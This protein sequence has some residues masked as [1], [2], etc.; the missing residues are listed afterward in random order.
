[1]IYL[2]G[3]KVWVATESGLSIIDTLSNT[4]FNINDNLA[5]RLIHEDNV[6]DIWL[7]SDSKG[8]HRVPRKLLS[9]FVK[10]KTSTLIHTH[11]IH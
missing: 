1:M 11:L 8:L 5:T 2:I 7:R 3:D 9:D 10:G 6:G 4:V